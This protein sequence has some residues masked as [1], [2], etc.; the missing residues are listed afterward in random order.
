MGGHLPPK[1]E[2]KTSGLTVSFFIKGVFQLLPGKDPIPWPK[3]PGHVSGDLPINGDKKQGLGYASDFVP[4]KPNAEFTAIGTAHPPEEATTSFPVRM[5]VGDRMREL[6]VF[7][8]WKWIRVHGITGEVPG[9]SGP[10]IP[11]PITYANAWGG[12][13]FALN[14]L[15]CGRVGEK[16]HLLEFP[17]SWIPNRDF[18]VGP[19]VFAPMPRDSPLRKSK[20]GTFDHQWAQTRWPWM[21]VNFDPS[22]YNSAHPKQWMNG[23]LRGDEELLFENMH[24]TIPLYRTRLPKLRARCFVTQTMNWSLDLKKEEAKRDFLEVPMDLDTLW[25]DMDQEKMIL[26]WRG[27]TPLRS[28]KLRDIDNLLILT[29]PLDAASNGLSHYRSLLDTEMESRNPNL[30]TSP[31]RSGEEIKAEVKAAVASALAEAAEKKTELIKELEAAFP[32]PSQNGGFNQALTDAKAA[33]MRPLASPAEGTSDPRPSNEIIS[34]ALSSAKSQFSQ[35]I[36]NVLSQPNIPESIKSSLTEKAALANDSLSKASLMNERIAKSSESLRARDREKFPEGKRFADYLDG[37]EPDLPRIRREG[38]EN[39]E[40]E[41]VDFSCL[42]LSGVNFRNASI[43]SC[44]FLNSCLA[45]ADFT[46]AKFDNVNLEGADLTAAILDD[47]DL[48]KCHLAGV[49][50]SKC[51]LNETRLRGMHLAGE[52]FAGAGGRRTDFSN[53]DLTM[54]NFQ[55]SDFRQ[56][57]FNKATLTRADFSRAILTSASFLG[58]QALEIIMDNADLTNFRGNHGSD[59]TGGRFRGIKAEKSIWERSTFDGADFR[60][61]HLT[62]ARFCEARLRNANFDR[63]ELRDAS[64]EDSLMSASQLTNANLFKVAFARADLSRAK[65]DGSNLYGAGFWDTILLHASWRDAN[66]KKTRMSR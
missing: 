46:G 13:D 27:R 33:F 6:K 7:G 5:H 34:E 16:T 38:L 28:L 51:S 42:D 25:V 36:G 54:A 53:S 22:C 66:I 60:I 49:T 43:R 44:S 9:P 10:L 2:P 21:P 40:M 48:R 23:Y 14:P 62:A 20:V 64:F 55:D 31:P 57:N 61:S 58:V 8:P 47:T 32:K 11:V 18:T 52:N 45:G 50:W 29:E 41:N 39:V 56:G 24:P 15:G 59:F 3:G 30:P 35:Q 12:P 26:V 17:D 65:M 4:Y 63:C 19:A 37:N 1:V